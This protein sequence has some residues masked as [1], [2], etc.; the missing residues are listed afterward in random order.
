[1]CSVMK[2][3]NKFKV[4]IIVLAILFFPITLLILCVKSIN[5]NTN[6]N[7]NSDEIT[8]DEVIDVEELFED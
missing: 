3:S 8:M 6:K 2:S 1:M 4:L 7:S 5:N